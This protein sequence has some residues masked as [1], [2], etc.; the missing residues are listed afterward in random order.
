MTLDYT[1]MV[2]AGGAAVIGLVSGS[3]GTY[4]VLRGQSLLGDAISHAALPGV[5]LAF[6]LTASKAPLTLA[7]GAA[8]AG[9]VGTLAV[10][11]V[12]R[13]SRVPFDAALGIVLSVFFGLGMV[14][15]T[16]VQRR[17][18][19]GQA[20][21]DRFL[22]GQAAALLP[23]DVLTMATLGTLA[24]A[25]M[26]L[27]WKEFKVLLFDP[28][29]AA[30]QGLPVRRL[31]VALTTLLVLAIVTGLQT[32][33]VVLM[34]ALVVAPAA[35][36][37]QWTD[38]LGGVV[39]LAGVFGAVSGAT[40][41]WISATA[42]GLPTGPVIVLVAS[43]VVGVSLLAAPRRG[44]VAAALR[45]RRNRKTL[46]L[47]GTLEDLFTLALQ[48]ADPHHPH[49]VAVLRT[50][51]TRPEAVDPTLA[52]LAER[53]WAAP[54]DGERWRLTERGLAEARRL[55]HNSARSS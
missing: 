12:V 14:L 13:R 17:P 42:A 5:V 37:R 36:A 4:A 40:G 16:L 19:A 9:W 32:V 26:L 31:D 25:A 3:L 44:L 43:A 18:D 8:V 33:G 27:F 54:A 20:G 21:L 2:V 53:G 52:S 34:S 39:A 6:L 35:A 50:M 7:A 22:F 11:G 24:L 23:R 38:R 51:T 45:A 41:A 49:A 48:H 29:F 28:D 1:L 55:A 10:T 15:L 47:T 30:A 46:R